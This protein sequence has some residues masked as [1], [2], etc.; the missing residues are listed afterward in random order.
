MVSTTLT[1]VKLKTKF[2][3]EVKIKGEK[4]ILLNKNRKYFNV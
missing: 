2:K 1:F 3:A 4:K